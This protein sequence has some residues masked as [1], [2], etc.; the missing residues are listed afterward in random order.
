M[1][2]MFTPVGGLYTCG[3]ILYQPL[4]TE[5]GD[6]AQPSTIYMT[7]SS[8]QTEA[9]MHIFQDLAAKMSDHAH[10]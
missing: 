2:C 6:F 9:D 4:K 7:I 10:H 3:T 8:G 1:C 5:S